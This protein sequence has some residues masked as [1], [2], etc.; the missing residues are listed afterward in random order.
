MSGRDKFQSIEFLLKI[1][2]KI[3]FFFP[4]WLKVFLWNS[5]NNQQQLIFVG[6]KYALLKSLVA[7]CGRNIMIG[8]NVRILNWESIKLGDNISI[9]DNCYIDATG[10]ITIGDNVSIAHSTSLLSSNH[11]WDIN[12]IPIKYNPLKKA[13]LF[14]ENDVWVGCGCRIMS[15]IKIKE[16]SIIA[17]GAVLT[18][19]TI[20]YSI[21]GGVPA[22]LIKEI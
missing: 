9:H 22:K 6:I 2:S 19:S 7:K 13:S 18:K 16:R 12:D 10:G 4:K 17:A 11:T 8:A 5:I 15:G 3:L 21:Y 14:I 1:L 20:G